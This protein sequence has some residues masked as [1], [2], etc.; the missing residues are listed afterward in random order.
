MLSEWENDHER[1]FIIKDTRYLDTIEHQW[2]EK[3]EVK[4]KEKMKRVSL[5]TTLCRSPDTT[6]FSPVHS[7]SPNKRPL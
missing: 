7:K 2:Q 6:C 4:E 1:Y 5:Q 3:N